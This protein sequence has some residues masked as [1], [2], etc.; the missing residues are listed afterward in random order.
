MVTSMSE[1]ST[2]QSTSVTCGPIQGSSKTYL[3]VDGMAVPHRRVHL[4]NGEHLDL[5]DT[6]GPYTDES[7]EIDL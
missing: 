1:S 2:T 6:S 5:Y 7:A 4:T 3:D